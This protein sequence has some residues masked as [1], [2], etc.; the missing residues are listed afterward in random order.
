VRRPAEASGPVDA[1]IFDMDGLLLDSERLSREALVRA[2]A[3]M[4]YRVTDA[5]YRLTIGAPADRCRELLRHEFGP[6]CPAE[7]LQA[8]HEACLHEMV[9]AGRLAIKEGA[10]ELLD[11]LDRG[12]RKR[13]IATS[14]SAARARLH[15]RAVGLDRRFDEIVTRDD[16]ARGKPAPDLFLEAARRLAIAPARCLVLEDSFNG[17]RAAE[18]AGMRVVMVPDLLDADAEMRRTAQRVVRTLHEIGACLV[19]LENA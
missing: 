10:T 8:A 19:D 14:S 4:G 3:A 15:L 13:A 12:R 1:V 6:D 2:G 5:F 7:R 11:Q 16:V 9:A 17:V 18:A